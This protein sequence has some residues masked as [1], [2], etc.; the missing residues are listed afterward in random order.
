[1]LLQAPGVAQDNMA[2]GA[3]HIRN[4]H[5]AAQYRINGVMLPDGV[6]FFGEGISPRF[7]QSMNLITGTLPA[8]YGLRTAASGVVDITTKSGVF[9]NGGLDRHLW[10]Q[11]LDDAAEHRLR[12]QCRT[13]G[14]IISVSG[15]F[16]HNDH[17][18]NQFAD[19]ELRCRA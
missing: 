3:I 15:D 9:Q 13:A 10:R 19:A 2:N 5:L 6:S 17:G 14:V 4:E 16:M 12:R 8:Q 7:I 11:L 1:M 18:I